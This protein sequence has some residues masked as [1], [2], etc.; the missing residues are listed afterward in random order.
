[1]NASR[2]FLQVLDGLAEAGREAREL[3]SNVFAL[4]R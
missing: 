1:V 3:L 2:E 4:R